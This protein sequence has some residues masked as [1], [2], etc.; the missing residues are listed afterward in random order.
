VIATDVAAAAALGDALARRIGG[1]RYQLWFENNTKFSWDDG[2][3]RVGVPNHF[4]Q[5]RLQNAFTEPVREAAQE[6]LGRT[7]EVRFFIDPELDRADRFDKGH[8]TAS[9]RSALK[10]IGNSISKS[11]PQERVEPTRTWGRRAMRAPR[12]WRRLGDFVVGPCNRVAH[13]SALSVVEAPGEGANP[14]VVYG[15]TGT[16]KTH[17]LEGIY[18]GLRKRH[19]DVRACL[20]H[21]EEFTNR[22]VEAMRSGKLAGFRHYFRDC[23]A[24]L[25]DDL[26]FLARKRATKEEFL[27]TFDAVQSAGGQVV[28]TCDC[29]PKLADELGPELVDRLVGGAVWGIVPPDGTTRLD[30]LRAKAGR[31]EPAVP[32]EVLRILASELSGNVREL[33]GALHS[34]RHYSRVAG[35][36][37]DV[38]LAREALGDLLRHCRKVYQLVDI[39]RAVCTALRLESGALQAADRTWAVSHPRMLAMYLSRKHTGAAYSEIGRHFG[40]RNHSTALA[41]EKKVRNWIRD[42]QELSLGTRRFKAREVLDMAERQL[43]R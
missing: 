30:I 36:P 4:L 12:H 32:E 23:D 10:T 18:A 2:L 14:V 27:H 15:A 40:G 11:T 20:A 21:S 13:A 43:F 29:H 41:A 31:G 9:R 6:V 5:Q 17:L 38:G 24:L 25:I 16:G 34:V 33:E 35:R 19:P 22:F 26:H 7:L 1:R 42:D 8:E 3:L 39:E 28:L 37:V